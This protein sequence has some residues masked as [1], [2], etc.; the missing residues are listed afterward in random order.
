MAES[1]LRFQ[2]LAEGRPEGGSD[3]EKAL[4]VGQLR[5]RLSLAAI[6]AQVECLLGRIHQA[7]NGNK[8][9]PKKREWSLIQDERMRRERQAHW[10][11]K[12]EGTRTIRKGAIKT[13]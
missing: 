11:S 10:I 4:I 6:K 7:G 3:Q 1:R 8:Q 13:A 2:V 12:I 9:L 5:R